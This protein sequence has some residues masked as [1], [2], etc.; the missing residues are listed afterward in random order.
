MDRLSQTGGYKKFQN[1]MNIL[2]QFL[3]EKLQTSSAPACSQVFPKKTNNSRI[4]TKTQTNQTGSQPRQ[5]VGVGG[6]VDVIR[7]NETLK[8]G[9]KAD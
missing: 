2:T 6:L 9:G 7:K 3:S 8:S 4:Y 1:L 5:V